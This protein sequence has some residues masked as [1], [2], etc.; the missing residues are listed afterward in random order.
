MSVRSR[1]SIA[2]A[3]V[4]ALLAG[5]TSLAGDAPAPRRAPKPHARAAAKPAAKPAVAPSS[6]PA[7]APVAPAPLSRPA[8]AGMVIG[9]DPET[10]LLGP[11]TPEQRLQLFG[12]EIVGLS[13]STAG[14]AERRLPD[15]G[16]LLDLGGR[17]QEFSY[18]RVAPG[19]R[20]VFGCASDAVTLR[21]AL[22][23]PLPQAPAP[24]PAL[25]DR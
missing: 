9:L 11:A 7:A 12:E 18:A 14:L 15:G 20:L 17:F 21:R 2:L 1:T 22:A 3:T 5:G 4:L 8:T 24:A 6:A 13:R 23:G 10:G 19:G 16:V 25:E